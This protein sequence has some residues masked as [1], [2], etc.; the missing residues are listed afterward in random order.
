[1]SKEVEVWKPSAGGA[2]AAMNLDADPFALMDI[3]D[4]DQNLGATLPLRRIEYLA[5]Q[6]AKDA[7]LERGLITDSVSMTQKEAVKCV[8]LAQKF[9][10]AYLPPFDTKADEQE[11]PFCVSLDGKNRTGGESE[12]IGDLQVCAHCPHSQWTDRE[13]PPACSDIYTLLLWDIE[14]QIPFVFNIRRTGIK[15]WR[16]GRQNLKLQAMK[17]RVGGFPANLCVSFELGAKPKDTYYLPTFGE[18]EAVPED[19][20]GMLAQGMESLLGSFQEVDPTKEPTVEEADETEIEPTAAKPAKKAP[21]KK[22]PAEKAPVPDDNDAGPENEAGNDGQDNEQATEGTVEAA[23]DT[24]EA[25]VEPDPTNANA[26]GFTGS[27]FAR[28]K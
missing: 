1:M 14:D 16:K 10:R 6:D 20:I 9:S 15:P 12:E 24:P 25:P 11:P 13:T 21:A 26:N 17:H 27:A 8:L 2:M 18:F 5:S 19:T 3:N 28:K 22:A 4:A 23:E 7:D